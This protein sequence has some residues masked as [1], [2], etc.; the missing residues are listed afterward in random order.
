MP[1]LSLSQTLLTVWQSELDQFTR[2]RV[3]TPARVE[4]ADR[5]SVLVSYLRFR[6]QRV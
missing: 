5:L 6:C 3:Y 4:R 2:D 1:A